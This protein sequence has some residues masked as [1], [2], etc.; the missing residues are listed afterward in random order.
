M[1]GSLFRDCDVEDAMARLGAQAPAQGATQ[2][3]DDCCPRSHIELKTN[4]ANNESKNSKAE[5]GS[6]FAPQIKALHASLNSHRSAKCYNSQ[7][8]QNISR[9]E[10]TSSEAAVARPKRSKEKSATPNNYSCPHCGRSFLQKSGGMLK[11]SEACARLH[12]RPMVDIDNGQELRKSTTTSITKKLVMSD[13]RNVS[14]RDWGAVAIRP[15]DRPTLA[16]HASTCARLT[17]PQVGNCRVSV[18]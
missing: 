13:L 14:L 8:A 4:S 10:R 15:S 5:R 7:S 1:A 9:S 12:A 18:R 17:V 11:H 16:S 2:K 3:M 6:A